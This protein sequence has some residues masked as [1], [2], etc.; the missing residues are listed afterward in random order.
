MELQLLEERWMG[1]TSSSKFSKFTRTASSLDSKKFH[2]TEYG[3]F[4]NFNIDGNIGVRSES[5]LKGN[6]NS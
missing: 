1:K 5:K 4:I 2:R 3:K 6:D